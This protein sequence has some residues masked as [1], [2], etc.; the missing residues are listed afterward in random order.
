MSKDSDKKKKKSAGCFGGKKKKHKLQDAP[1]LEVNSQERSEERSAETSAEAAPTKPARIMEKMPSG[2]EVYKTTKVRLKSNWLEKPSR[3]IP[4]DQES[5]PSSSSK[6]KMDTPVAFPAVIRNQSTPAPTSSQVETTEAR[7]KW[8]KLLDSSRKSSDKKLDLKKSNTSSGTKPSQ[9]S[10]AP[11]TQR[12]QSENPEHLSNRSRYSNFTPKISDSVST[13]PNNPARVVSINSTPSIVPAPLKATPSKINSESRKARFSSTRSFANNPSGSTQLSAMSHEEG[14]SLASSEAVEVNAELLYT[15]TEEKSSSFSEQSSSASPRLERKFTQLRL[16]QVDAGESTG[17]LDEAFAEACTSFLKQCTSKM[18]KDIE[19]AIKDVLA[20]N[21]LEYVV[22]DAAELAFRTGIELLNA[23]HSTRALAK[24]AEANQLKDS[25]AAIFTYAGALFKQLPTDVDLR[26]STPEHM[27]MIAEAFAS[28]D[29]I[30]RFVPPATPKLKS[31]TEIFVERLRTQEDIPVASK[32]IVQE[33]LFALGQKTQKALAKATIDSYNQYES[34]K[35]KTAFLTA[36][37]KDDF[38]STKDSKEFFELDQRRCMNWAESLTSQAIALGKDLLAKDPSFIPMYV[39]QLEKQITFCYEN[40]RDTDTYN[41]VQGFLTKL[42]NVP[43]TLTGDAKKTS[44]N[45]AVASLVRLQK[46]FETNNV[47]T[48]G[49]QDFLVKKVGQYQKE[50]SDLFLSQAPQ[51]ASAPTSVTA[52]QP[53]DSR[54]KKRAAPR[55]LATTTAPTATPS[56]TPKP[57]LTDTP[58]PVAAPVAASTLPQVTVAA[59]EPVASPLKTKITAEWIQNLPTKE[60]PLSDSE[61][62]AYKKFQ[63]SKARNPEDF[64]LK[65]EAMSQSQQFIYF[66]IVERNNYQKLRDLEARRTPSKT[67]VSPVAQQTQ[68]ST[69]PT[70]VPASARSNEEE[71]INKIIALKATLPRAEWEE[72]VQQLTPELKAK[73]ERLENK[74]EAEK[75]TAVKFQSP[76]KALAAQF[77]KKDEEAQRTPHITPSRQTE[78]SAVPHTLAKSPAAAQRYLD[79]IKSGAEGTQTPSPSQVKRLTARTVADNSWI[80]Q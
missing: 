57:V 64:K 5:N 75:D 31:Y 71:V 8:E 72:A 15:A 45:T 22:K 80:K 14:D 43:D 37:G 46:Y 78:T 36:Q 60:Q 19:R 50:L 52:S 63:E 34:P 35:S 13:N 62:V 38:I 12:A 53:K 33:T 79:R 54:G 40:L 68:L 4:V 47:S 70:H 44:I 67:L 65:L 18:P 27:K 74:L 49:W 24:F 77:T 20:D 25:T 51:N 59:P 41:K 1:Q 73:L 29:L 48:R 69:E 7:K 21:H 10:T 55:T 11:T 9:K 56:A 16:M 3:T 76:V 39:A 17:T 32:K 26:T 61:E 66:N 6:E 28:R 30:D 58:D 42:K 23:S 2:H